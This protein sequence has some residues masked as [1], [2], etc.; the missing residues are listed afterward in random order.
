MRTSSAGECKIQLSS[1]LSK[2]V[3]KAMVTFNGSRTYS[4]QVRLK[5]NMFDGRKSSDLSGTRQEERGISICPDL[6]WGSNFILDTMHK[7]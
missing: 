7:S 1:K 6:F 4:A 3:E 5:G 2:F